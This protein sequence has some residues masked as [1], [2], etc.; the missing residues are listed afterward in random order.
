MAWS[1]SYSTWIW[2]STGTTSD[3]SI[4]NDATATART[5]KVTRS[6][7]RRRRVENDDVVSDGTRFLLDDGCA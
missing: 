1:V 6:S 2:A 5:A 4:T 7:P 3:C